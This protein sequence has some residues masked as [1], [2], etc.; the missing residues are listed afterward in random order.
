MSL[1]NMIIELTKE[2]ERLKAQIKELIARRSDHKCE[3]GDKCKE[4]GK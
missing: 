2:N 3:C 1:T 4:E